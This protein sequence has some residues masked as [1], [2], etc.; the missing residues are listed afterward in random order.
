MHGYGDAEEA[1]NHGMDAMSV[2]FL[3]TKKES[4]GSSGEKVLEEKSTYLSTM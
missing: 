4:V 2:E 3:S 1:I